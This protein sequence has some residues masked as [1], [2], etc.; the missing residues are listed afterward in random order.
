M[1]PIHMV[2]DQCFGLDSILFLYSRRSMNNPSLWVY[3]HSW[4]LVPA[5]SLA[6]ALELLSSCMFFELCAPS[7]FHARSTVTTLERDLVHWPQFF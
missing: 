1:D 5:Q 7:S 3:V 6:P 2:A 4:S